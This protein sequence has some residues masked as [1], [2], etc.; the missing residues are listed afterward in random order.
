MFAVRTNQYVPV[1]AELAG[2]L[3]LIISLF[4]F[5]HCSPGTTNTRNYTFSD[6]SPGSMSYPTR[7][8]GFQFSTS[9]HHLVPFSGE[10]MTL[11]LS[12][13]L[14]VYQYTQNRAIEEVRNC[15]NLQTCYLESSRVVSSQSS[16]LLSMAGKAADHGV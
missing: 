12:V 3:P 9:A 2:V 14:A 7:Y 13:L 1:L 4:F 11:R 10:V 16:Q 5:L 15:A 6:P 8:F